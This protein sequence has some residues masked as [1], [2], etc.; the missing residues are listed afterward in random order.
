MQ[1]LQPRGPRHGRAGEQ[2]CKRAYQSGSQQVVPMSPRSQVTCGTVFGF[3]K[4]FGT[5][6]RATKLSAVL[7]MTN[8]RPV[9]AH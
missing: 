9:A 5:G 8:A 2:N 4:G 3:C 7:L 6:E 1:Q